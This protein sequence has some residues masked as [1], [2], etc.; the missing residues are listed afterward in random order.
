MTS[1]VM[2]FC[3]QDGLDYM[4]NGKD[5]VFI[6]SVTHRYAGLIH[7]NTGL[8]QINIQFKLRILIWLPMKIGEVCKTT[9]SEMSGN[10]T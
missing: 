9:T 1:K 8:T 10:F 3:C 6:Y 5:K 7:V 4:N 2:C